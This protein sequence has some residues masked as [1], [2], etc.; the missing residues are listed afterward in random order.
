MAVYLDKL[1]NVSLRGRVSERNGKFRG[2]NEITNLES[3]KS[4]TP[5]TSLFVISIIIIQTTDL[6]TIISSCK[7]DEITKRE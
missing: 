2:S 3:D 6:N 7:E 5:K 4:K 1:K